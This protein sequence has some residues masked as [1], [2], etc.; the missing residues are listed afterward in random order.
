MARRPGWHWPTRPFGRLCR[1]T[2]QNMQ[3]NAAHLK[4][5]L[6]EYS[7]AFAKDDTTNH[8]VLT[9]ELVVHVVFIGLHVF[10]NNEGDSKTGVSKKQ[11]VLNFLLT[12]TRNSRTTSLTLQPPE[13]CSTK[14]WW[15]HRTTNNYFT[16]LKGRW[17]EGDIM[18]LWKLEC[19]HEHARLHV[20]QGGK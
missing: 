3:P 18:S 4:H 7:N 14:R 8:T 10:S 6:S 13:L 16:G 20:W 17:W 5:A 1:I 9:Q 15:G 11:S 2:E 19:L 12:Q